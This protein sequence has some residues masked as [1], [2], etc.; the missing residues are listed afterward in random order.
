MS[1]QDGEQ[2]SGEVGQSTIGW[3]ELF[4]D[5]VVVAAVAVLTEGLRERPD[6]GGLGMLALLY[7]AIWLSWVSVV[8]YANLAREGTRVPTVVFAM[9]LVAVMAATAPAHFEERA[10]WFAVAFLLLRTTAARASMS[11]GRLLA[12]WP[13]L[14]FG[15]LAAPWVVAMWVDPPW[16]FALWGLGLVVDLAFVLFRGDAELDEQ[17]ARLRA[18]EARHPRREGP[19]RF[20]ELTVVDVDARHLDERL[21]LFV[22]I[23]LGEAVSQIVVPAATVEWTSDLLPP[24]IIGFVVLAG[25]WWLTFS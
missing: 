3:L 5:L 22:I 19:G 8:L 10:N 2:D 15:G 18:K 21:G 1:E 7:G 25:L 16:K 20:E 6:L 13:L 9:F 24:A 14:Q 17:V 12:G 11:T 4:F 23:V